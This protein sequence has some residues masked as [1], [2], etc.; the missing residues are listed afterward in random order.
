[1]SPKPAI[2]AVGLAIVLCGCETATPYQHLAAGAAQSGGFTDQRLDDSRYRVTF[3]GNT[4]TSARTVANDLIYRSAELT[5]KSGYDWFQT[6]D[7]PAPQDGDSWVE[8]WGPGPYGYYRSYWRRWVRPDTE[9]I[10]I[11]RGP[12]FGAV[13]NPY[14]IE[15][16]RASA[17]IAMAHGPKPADNPHAMDARQVLAS[18]GAVIQRPKT[19]S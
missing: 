13:A 18:F 1:M 15:A 19:L 3:Q 16:F 4:M 11:G 9:W 10:S 5:V 17:D 14:P 6:V 8:T 2:L 12:H 7:Q